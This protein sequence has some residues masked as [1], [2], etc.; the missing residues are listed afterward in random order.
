[1]DTFAT[2]ALAGPD[3]ARIDEAAAAARNC[4][5]SLEARL[6]MFRPRSDVSRINAAAGQSPVEISPVAA[7]CLRLA[8]HYAEVS[9]GAF[10][11]T[12]GPLVRAW[13]I[14]GGAVPGTPPDEAALRDALA[15]VGIRHVSLS[16]GWARL[17]QAGSSI[18]LGGIAKGYGADLCYERLCSMGLTAFLVDLGGN[19]RCAGQPRPGEPWRIGVRNPF[20]RE[21]LIGALALTNS[22]AVATSGNYERFVEIQ[23]ERYGHIVD[24]R[25][26]LPVK[27]MAAVTVVSPSAVE[28]DALS[29]SLFV[30]GP[31][32][33]RAARAGAPGCEALF[34]PD[35][36]P[37]EIWIT[38][39]LSRCFTPEPDVADCVRVLE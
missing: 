6:S 9:G 34:V 39:G 38:P 29:T 22:Q 35:R 27:G 14:H 21:R 2:L 33:S 12:V 36:R 32:G 15:R 20:D 3:A 1:M 16:N 11:V 10:D 31:E 4:S 18:D 26:G 24:P 19:M 30:L 13:G 28:A 17:D 8:I 5:T 37:M 23:G 25:T 7:E